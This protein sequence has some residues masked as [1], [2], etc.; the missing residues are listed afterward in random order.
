MYYRS[1][2]RL[3]LKL[4]SA[5]GSSTLVTQTALESMGTTACTQT[6]LTG[7]ARSTTRLMLLTPARDTV[8][9]SSTFLLLSTSIYTTITT[10]S[11]TV[12]SKSVAGLS[13]QVS[14]EQSRSSRPSNGSQQV[15]TTTT[16][17]TETTKELIWRMAARQDSVA[18]VLPGP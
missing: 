12:E 13:T 8:S 11:V 15:T 18:T 17:I 7:S 10:S 2:T 5:C 6:K 1:T 4:F 16:I 14:L 3:A 9:Y